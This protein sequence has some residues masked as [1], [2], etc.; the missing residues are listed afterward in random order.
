MPAF[1]QVQHRCGC[2]DEIY[3]GGPNLLI[4]CQYHLAIA[5]NP[6]YKQRLNTMLPPLQTSTTIPGIPSHAF[7][8]FQMGGGFHPGQMPPPG[9]NIRMQTPGTSR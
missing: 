7:H 5:N 1:Q 9:V 3:V 4:M 6:G 2:V 8:P